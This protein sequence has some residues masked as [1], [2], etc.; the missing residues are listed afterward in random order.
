MGVADSCMVMTPVEN[1]FG[2]VVEKSSHLILCLFGF[3]KATKFRD[4]SEF[5]EC[6][7]NVAFKEL[8]PWSMFTAVSRKLV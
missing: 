5:S 2:Q 1:K 8:P 7:Q 3:V 4:S 6:V